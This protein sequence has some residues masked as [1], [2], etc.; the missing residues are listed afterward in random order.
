VD[1]NIFAVGGWSDDFPNFR[2]YQN[3]TTNVSWKKYTSTASDMARD[4]V[5][6]FI[7]NSLNLDPNRPRFEDDEYGSW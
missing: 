6:R 7:F 1:N 5:G 3:E 2:R 4:D